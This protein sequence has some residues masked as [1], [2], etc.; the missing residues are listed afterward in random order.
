MGSISDTAGPTAGQPVLLHACC[1][2][3]SAAVVERMLAEDLKPTVFFCN[4]N[5]HPL[6]EWEIRRDE[7][8]RYLDKL[9]VPCQIDDDDHGAWLEAVKGMEEEPERGTRCL[10]CMEMR[11]ERTAEWAARNGFRWF[12]T[13]LS[14]SRWKDWG[15]ICAAGNK[16]EKRNPGTLFW[17]RSWRK[18][19]LQER[20]AAMLRSEGF[21]N[22]Q[23]CGCEF[24]EQAMLKR[25]AK[26][27][28]EA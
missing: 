2:P 14:S 24:S 18:G 7:L 1:A 19:G 10:K 3:C 27:G 20:R 11:M 26:H 23:Y 6:K 8:I 12:T 22:Q 9:H 25:M 5:I 28:K 15:Q 13:T 4:P 21:Y 16:A 17:E